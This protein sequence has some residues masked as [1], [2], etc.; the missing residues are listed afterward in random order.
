MSIYLEVFHMSNTSDL[1]RLNISIQTVDANLIGHV[2]DLP[3]PVPGDKVLIAEGVAVTLVDQQRRRGIGAVETIELII[4]LASSVAA[5]VIGS[6]LYDKLKDRK[7]RLSISGSE[8]SQPDKERI[9]AQIS[10]EDD[11]AAK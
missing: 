8:F 1:R 9:I 11:D 2:L 3:S 4:T 7:A 5:Q 10:K 6:W